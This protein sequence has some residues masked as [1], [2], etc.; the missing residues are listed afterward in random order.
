VE[1]L[2]AGGAYGDVRIAN[3]CYLQ[4]APGRRVADDDEEEPDVPKNLRHTEGCDRRWDN[5]WRSQ[6]SAKGGRAAT[7]GGNMMQE[8]HERESNY[9]KFTATLGSIVDYGANT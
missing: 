8:I 9:R 1:R 7:F 2:G 6:E 3:V 4:A 5:R